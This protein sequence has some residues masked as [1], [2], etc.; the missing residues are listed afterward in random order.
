MEPTLEK[1]QKMAAKEAI[2]FLSPHLKDFKRKN[3]IRIRQYISN[4]PKY[5]HLLEQEKSTLEMIPAEYSDKKLDISLYKVDKKNEVRERIRATT[6]LDKIQ[7]PL[8]AADT[9]QFM[10]D[11]RKLVLNINQGSQSRL[12]DYVVRRRVTLQFLRDFLGAPENTHIKLEDAIHNLIFPMKTTSDEVRLD[13]TN[14]WIV[15]ERFA[16]HKFLSSDKNAY[17]SVTVMKDKPK[18][19]TSRHDILLG[20]SKDDIFEYSLAST[21]DSLNVDSL[22]IVEFKKPLR[23]DYTASKNP[24]EQIIQYALDI[25]SGKVYNH[26]RQKIEINENQPIFCYVIC[27][28]TDSL[29][30]V[31]DN[32]G[33]TDLPGEGGYFFIHPTKKIFLTV[34]SY[35]K[36]VNDAEKRNEALFDQLHIR[37]E[38]GYIP[39]PHANFAKNAKSDSVTK[40]VAQPKQFDH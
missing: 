26:R 39:R 21:T 32:R 40:Q 38:L 19:S 23:D 13:E 33:F 16:Y 20:F 12:V 10:R 30:S 24:I 18:N 25:R 7:R 15:D 5:R 3:L 17:K 6:L 4:H 37:N 36:L 28:I 8:N 27:D 14:L 34:M 9:E 1:I 11:V 2:K 29:K 22:A 35:K 31:I